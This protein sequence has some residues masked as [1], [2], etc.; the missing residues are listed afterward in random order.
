MKVPVKVVACASEAEVGA[1]VLDERVVVVMRVREREGR[2][3]ELPPAEAEG[4]AEAE[5]DSEAERVDVGAAEL[6]EVFK[7]LPSSSAIPVYRCG[8]E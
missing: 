7:E 4:V 3:N 1:E 5:L 8:G 2:G 6:V